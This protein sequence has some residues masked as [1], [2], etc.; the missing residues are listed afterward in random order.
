MYNINKLAIIQGG[1]FNRQSSTNTSGTRER[2]RE[3]NIHNILEPNQGRY[4]TPYY[5]FFNIISYKYLLYV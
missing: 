1:T 2:E 5:F 4:I 3:R